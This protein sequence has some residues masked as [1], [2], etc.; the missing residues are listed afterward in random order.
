MRLGNDDGQPRHTPSALL[1]ALNAR[2]RTAADERVTDVN[3]LRRQV[4]FE[5]ILVRL[6]ADD[7]GDRGRWVLKGGLALELRLNSKCRATKDLDIA[8][9]DQLVD[10]GDVRAMLIEA[11]AGD[12]DRDHFSFAVGMP[13]QLAVDQGGRSGWRFPV[14]VRLAGKTFASVRLDVVARASEI[15]GAVESLAFQSVLAVD[16]TRG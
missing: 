5:R 10:G 9:T 3:R 14:D 6:A 15:A 8:L 13:Q 12:R 1:A 11:L 2:L 4:A 16:P 7:P